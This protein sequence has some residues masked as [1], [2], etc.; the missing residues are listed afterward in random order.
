MTH[1]V[2]ERS[3]VAIVKDD[4]RVIVGVIFL[5]DSDAEFSRWRPV[6]RFG[7]TAEIS[8]R[9]VTDARETRPQLD[10]Y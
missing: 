2:L 5:H 6:R 8:A 7:L 1:P 4:P 10:R 3:I 9:R